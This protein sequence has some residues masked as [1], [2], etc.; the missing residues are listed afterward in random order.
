MAAVIANLDL[1]VTSDT[2]IAHLAGAL[3]ASV[4]KGCVAPSRRLAFFYATGTIPPGIP[5]CG[6][7]DK[8]FAA[9]GPRFS[10]PHRRR[11]QGAS[12]RIDYDSLAGPLPA[13][14]S[15]AAAD[16]ALLQSRSRQSIS[17]ATDLPSDSADDDGRPTAS[18]KY[19]PCPRKRC[20]S[21]APAG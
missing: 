8:R 10:E 3:G 11:S 13:S 2:A 20:V 7:S 5:P 16:A 19:A 21:C 1:V 18:K 14:P 6:S 4:S 15:Y 17:L 12:A 9:I